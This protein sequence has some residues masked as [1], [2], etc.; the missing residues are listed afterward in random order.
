MSLLADSERLR[1]K[2]KHRAADG[3]SMRTPGRTLLA[4]TEDY[5]VEPLPAAKP[6]SAASHPHTL[7][8]PTAGEDPTVASAR[9]LL[10]QTDNDPSVQLLAIR[11]VLEQAD[12][13]Q[14]KLAV[15]LLR[16]L[17]PFGVDYPN[18]A[19][20]V[21]SRLSQLEHGPE[22]PG[23]H[24]DHPAPTDDRPQQVPA[25]G[26]TGGDGPVITPLNRKQDRQSMTASDPGLPARQLAR[27]KAEWEID[28][29]YP[30]FRDEQAFAIQP[31]ELFHQ[32]SKIDMNVPLVVRR[33][34]IGQ[35][36]SE[37]SGLRKPNRNFGGV[38]FTDRPKDINT[39]FTRLSRSDWITDEQY[40][41]D[42]DKYY[43]DHAYGYT[44]KQ[45]L[46]NPNLRYKKVLNKLLVNWYGPRAAYDNWEPAA[47]YFQNLIVG[48]HYRTMIGSPYPEHQ[49]LARRAWAGEPEAYLDMLET[50][51]AFD[52]HSP[53][54]DPTTSKP[55]PHDKA[56]GKMAYNGTGGYK[57][58]ALASVT[59]ALT[60]ETLRP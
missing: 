38:E 1:Q 49:D 27:Q 58:Q 56:I 40:H 36:L 32:I 18:I 9:Q 25:T 39:L 14:P 26:T 8:P 35:V 23:Q 2:A 16:L 20:V 5:D 12:I 19:T 11:R 54:K 33:M 30:N 45:Q 34:M 17:A 47:L 28:R 52:I 3:L 4:T 41:A 50:N 43:D 6:T 57:H 13:S 24:E 37:Q 46:E 7:P 44:I 53:A 59:R 55:L 31:L 48:Y 15:Q 21:S 29:T 60:D 10:Q 51:A 22:Q 42:P